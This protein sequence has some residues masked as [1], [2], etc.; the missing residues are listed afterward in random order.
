MIELSCHKNEWKNR[1]DDFRA[2]ILNLAQEIIIEIEHIGSTS[3]AEVKAKD[4]IDTQLAIESFDKM[5]YLS[6]ILESLGFS[7]IDSVKQDHVPFHDFNY[8]ESGWEKRFF[9]GKYKGQDFNIH[10]RV[11]N[12]LNWKFAL[13]F[14]NYLSENE[15]AKYAFLQFKERLAKANVSTEDYCMIKDSVIDHLS[16]QFKE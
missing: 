14:K 12:S 16:L 15:M 3:I 4:I 6:P 7:C 13:N 9:K 5:V 2:E 11:H 10:V 1:F 8:F